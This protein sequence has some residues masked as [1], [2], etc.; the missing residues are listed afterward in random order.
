MAAGDARASLGR[1]CEAGS[2]TEDPDF[3]GRAWAA[4]FNYLMHSF[5][6]LYQ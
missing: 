2:I 6:F 4:V 3:I 5:E 1:T